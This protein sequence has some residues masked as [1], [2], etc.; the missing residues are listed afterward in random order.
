[1][2]HI[3]PASWKMGGMNGTG[4]K[5]EVFSEYQGLMMN[6]NFILTNT[7]SNHYTRA[8]YMSRHTDHQCGGCSFYAGFNHDYGLC[9]LDESPYYLETVFEH[10][11]CEKY[12]FEDWLYHSF[13]KDKR[14][15]VFRDTLFGWLNSCKNAIDGAKGVGFVSEELEHISREIHDAL[16]RRSLLKEHWGFM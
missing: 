3:V 13:E 14:L 8:L 9:C 1:M 6:S 4:F 5:E 12:I 15:L 2:R 11:G 10:F 7:F 16:H